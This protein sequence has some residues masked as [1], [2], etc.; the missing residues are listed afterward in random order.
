MPIYIPEILKDSAVDTLV[1]AGIVVGLSSV[2]V[3]GLGRLVKMPELTQLGDIGKVTAAFIIYEALMRSIDF[4]DVNQN[5]L[6]IPID[7]PVV[8]P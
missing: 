2:A 6:A 7:Q 1:A 3:S 5:Q 4:T 8:N